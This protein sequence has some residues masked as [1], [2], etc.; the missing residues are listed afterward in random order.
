MAPKI[1]PKAIPYLIWALT[2]VALKAGTVLFS[3]AGAS[4]VSVFTGVLLLYIP[5][6]YYISARREIRFLNIVSLRKS[7]F[8]LIIFITAT[9]LVYTTVLK[10]SGGHYEKARLAILFTKKS[11]IFW[12]S[13]L[14]AVGLPEEFFFRGFLYSEIEGSEVKKIAVTS[15]LF[16]LTHLA[17][18]ASLLRAMTVFPGIVLALLRSRTKEIYTPALL[19]TFM[20]LINWLGPL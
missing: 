17:V 13:S 16:A 14:L 2:T 18:G 7:L 6:I 10:I 5:F 12:G 15:V 4:A 19:H 11:W 8:W 1:P 3:Q 9:F 20:N